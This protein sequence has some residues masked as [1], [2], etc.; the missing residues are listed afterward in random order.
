[1]KMFKA[2]RGLTYLAAIAMATQVQPLA[3]QIP[4]NETQG[5]LEPH[6]AADEAISRIKSPY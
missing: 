1:M 6:P 4:G 5:P 3:A 2:V